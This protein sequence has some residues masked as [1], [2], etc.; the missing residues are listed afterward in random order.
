MSFL[1]DV[2][3][4]ASDL[5]PYRWPIAIGTAILFA[6]VIAFACRRRWHRVLWRHKLAT[7]VIV[8][9]LLAAAIPAGWYTLSP[10]WERSHLKEASPLEAVTVDAGPAGSAP[11]VTA[12][13]EVPG[14]GVPS[15]TPVDAPFVARITHRGE[16]RGADDFH[17]GRGAAQ[18]IET[19]PGRYTLRFENFSVRNGPDLFV[20]LSPYEDGY[21][22]GAVNL[23]ELKATDGAF[24]YEVP[25][26]VDVSQFRSAIVWCK[27][28]SVL[29]A[30]APLEEIQ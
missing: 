17:F 16:F 13:S 23:G 15:A 28:F 26:E 4:F 27:R 11:P 22:D 14:S 25:A 29:F 10:L 24:N 30:A 20:Y 12:P 8:A 1:G 9:P 18:L 3:R 5:Y 7:A 2:E 21:G 6:A 19:A